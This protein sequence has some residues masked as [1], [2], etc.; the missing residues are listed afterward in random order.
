MGL[1]QYIYRLKQVGD[2]TIK[3]L[4]GKKVEELDWHKY[5]VMDKNGVDCKPEMYKDIMHLLRPIKLIESY[6]DVEK[7]KKDAGVPE[8]WSLTCRS[9]MGSEI[10]YT[11]G[12]L[13]GHISATVNKDNEDK[14]VYE[15][16]I[17]SY[18]CYCKEVYYTRKEYEIQ[19]IMY[20]LYE[21]DIEN[22]GY[23]HMSEDMIEALNEGEGKKVL[24]TDATNL[25]YHEWY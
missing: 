4:Q 5:L 17:E 15:K 18:I 19:D 12:D 13:N 14:Y 21:G 22:C 25:Y 11:W 10:T 9:I 20:D 16:E 23:H 7:L 1:D 3:A 2:K 6:V 24:D 8:D